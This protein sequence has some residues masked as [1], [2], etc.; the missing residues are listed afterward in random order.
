[1]FKVLIILT[2]LKLV[3]TKKPHIIVIVA[4]DLVSLGK[5]LIFRNRCSELK[6]IF[7]ML[8]FDDSRQPVKNSHI[9]RPQLL[10]DFFC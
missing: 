3:L 9:Q 6:V 7:K 2:T 4:D 8:D 5:I 10:I 1:M